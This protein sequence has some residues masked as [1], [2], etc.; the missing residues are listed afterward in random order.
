MIEPE[1]ICNRHDFYPDT[2][3]YAFALEL[4]VCVVADYRVLYRKIAELEETIRLA[5]E[6]LSDTK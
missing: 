2:P 1:E 4:A 6:V 3:G 5:R